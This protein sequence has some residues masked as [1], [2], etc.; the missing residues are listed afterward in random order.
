MQIVLVL[1]ECK[2]YQSTMVFERE[3]VWLLYVHVEYQYTYTGV[4]QL[5]CRICCSGV[6]S[7]ELVLLNVSLY[8]LSSQLSDIIKCCVVALY[9]G[10]R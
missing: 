1:L 3:I 5:E 6:V 4:Y 2:K 10:V 9:G 8:C 7:L